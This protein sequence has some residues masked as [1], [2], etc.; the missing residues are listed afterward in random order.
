MLHADLQQRKIEAEM[1]GDPLAMCPSKSVNKL[2][3][4]ETGFLA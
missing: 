4:Q 3:L 1:T 2:G